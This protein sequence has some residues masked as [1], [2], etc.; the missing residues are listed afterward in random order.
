MVHIEGSDGQARAEHCLAASTAFQI[1]IF[2]LPA[3]A[4][5]VDE[6]ITSSSRC[7]RYQYYHTDDRAPSQRVSLD[8]SSHSRSARTLG[9]ATSRKVFK[10]KAPNACG[11]NPRTN[12][13]QTYRVSKVRNAKSSGAQSRKTGQSLARGRVF[14]HRSF[15]Q[16]IVTV[17]EPAS[18]PVV[19]SMEPGARKRRKWDVAAPQGVP[20]AQTTTN[21]QGASGVVSAQSKPGQPLTDDLK[22]R[23]QQAAAAAVAKISQASYSAV[24]QDRTFRLTPFS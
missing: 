10:F 19:A 14:S 7:L 5:C 15:A 23:A 11:Q 2:T 22:A 8:T 9:L 1:Q 6:R 18:A 12:P 24:L 13:A 3:S 17:S 21:L 4:L 20:A 16:G